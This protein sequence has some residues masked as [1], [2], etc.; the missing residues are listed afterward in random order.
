MYC[1]KCRVPEVCSGRCRVLSDSPNTEQAT[2]LHPNFVHVTDDQLEYDLELSTR[3]GCRV[4]HGVPMKCP[5]PKWCTG[6]SF[7][8]PKVCSGRRRVL[9]YSPNT[10]QATWLHPNFVH[11]TD[12][13]LEYYPHKDDPDSALLR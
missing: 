12:E 11:V 6:E 4:P 13:Q 5:R 9:S 3:D 7:A 8:S 10:H 1:K 2:W